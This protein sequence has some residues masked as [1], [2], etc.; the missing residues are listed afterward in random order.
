MCAPKLSCSPKGSRTLVTG[1][2]R[3]SSS[4]ALLG[5]LSGIFLKPSMSSEKTISWVGIASSVS[6][7]KALRTMVGRAASPKVP[8]CGRPDAP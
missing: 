4:M 5:T 3:S 1:L 2:S 6:A 8:M 7:R